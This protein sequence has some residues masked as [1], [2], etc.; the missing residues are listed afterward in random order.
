M[1]FFYEENK[2]IETKGMIA[3]TKAL[4]AVLDIN[5]FWSWNHEYIL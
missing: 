2:Q 1:F 4:I 5:L 3:A